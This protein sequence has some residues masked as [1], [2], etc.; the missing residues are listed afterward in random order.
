MTPRRTVLAGLALA[1]EAVRPARAQPSMPLDALPPPGSPLPNGFE[2][3]R[4][5]RGR[6]GRWKV[7]AVGGRGGPLRPRRPGRRAD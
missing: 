4:T 5:G 7:G 1:A 6:P 3:A 2:A